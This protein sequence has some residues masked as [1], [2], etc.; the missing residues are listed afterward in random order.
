MASRGVTT[1]DMKNSIL[2]KQGPEFLRLPKENFP[3]MSWENIDNTPEEELE[4]RKNKMA[5]LTATIK[6]TKI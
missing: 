6:Q 4:L 5:V 2:W 3:K 1:R